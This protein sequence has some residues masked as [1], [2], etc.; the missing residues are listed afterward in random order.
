MERNTQIII[1]SGALLGL[2]GLYFAWNFYSEQKIE[3]IVDEKENE[4]KNEI[5]G[6]N[7]IIE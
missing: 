6:K 4:V 7:E 3:L 2:I 1:G 5:I